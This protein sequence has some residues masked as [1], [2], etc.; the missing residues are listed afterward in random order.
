MIERKNYEGIYIFNPFTLLE[1]YE[2][3]INE[4]KE[5]AT[6][7]YEYNIVGIKTLAYEIKKLKEG[8]FVTFKYSLTE[9]ELSKIE[10][11]AKDNDNIIKFINIKY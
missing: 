3:A 11:Q 9:E 6:I 8:F 7:I 10:L 2:K 5:I 1:E 4:I